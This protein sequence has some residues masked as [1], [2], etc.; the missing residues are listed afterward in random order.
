MG[1][2]VKTLSQGKNRNGVGMLEGEGH[3]VGKD[4]CCLAGE[5]AQGLRGMPAF[6]EVLSSIPSNYM[7]AHNHL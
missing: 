5:M 7:M 1:Q 4:T 6:P 2:L 3:S